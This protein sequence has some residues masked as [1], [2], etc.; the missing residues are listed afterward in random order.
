MF[1][2]GARLAGRMVIFSAA[3]VGAATLSG[4]GSGV[5][6]AGQTDCTM[7]LVNNGEGISK[8][9]LDACQLGIDGDVMGC[10]NMLEQPPAAR[11]QAV[12]EAACTAAN[13]P[14]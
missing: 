3:V 12:A 7:Y 11:P 1:G 2:F 5:A 10:V 6:N 9:E 14:G 4:F 13:R 8:Y